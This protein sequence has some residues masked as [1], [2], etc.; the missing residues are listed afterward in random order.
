MTL[1][2]CEG[3]SERLAELLHPDGLRVTAML[4]VLNQ[5]VHP[6]SMI[7]SPRCLEECPLTDLLFAVVFFLLWVFLSASRDELK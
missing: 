5:K 4:T 1:S 3:L 7:T 6:D 2:V